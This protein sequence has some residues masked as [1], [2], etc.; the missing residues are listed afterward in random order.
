MVGDWQEGRWVCRRR[1]QVLVA[2]EGQPDMRN[3]EGV[4]RRIGGHY[5]YE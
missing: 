1:R 5:E 2:Y 4:N 3:E